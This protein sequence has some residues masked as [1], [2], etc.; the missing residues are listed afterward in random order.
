MKLFKKLTAGA[1]F[2]LASL[3]LIAQAERDELVTPLHDS[4]NYHQIFNVNTEANTNDA[5]LGD[6][7]CAD[8]F[9]NCSLKAALDEVYLIR[10]G[11]SEVRGRDIL[12]RIMVDTIRWDETVAPS[13]IATDYETGLNSGWL[14]ELTSSVNLTIRGYEEFST[15]GKST[16]ILP[17][18]IQVLQLKDSHLW[19]D[20]FDIQV[21][22]SSDRTNTDENLFLAEFSNATV[23]LTEV[24]A[25]RQ[26]GN[27]FFRLLKLSGKI[28]YGED[29]PLESITSYLDVSNSRFSGFGFPLNP[30]TEEPMLPEIDLPFPSGGV[31]LLERTQASFLDTYFEKST[32]AL[33]GAINLSGRAGNDRLTINNSE[34]VNNQAKNGGAVKANCDCP[35]SINNSSFTLN[36]AI[37]VPGGSVRSFSG[38]GAVHFAFY[39]AGTFGLPT[40]TVTNSSFTQNE[41]DQGGA[42]FTDGTQAQNLTRNLFSQNLA[43]RSGGAAYL[44]NSDGN[45]S[46]YNN[47]FS[48]NESLEVSALHISGNRTSDT[49][50][51]KVDI[52]I[53]QSNFIANRSTR[54]DSAVSL[55][56]FDSATIAKSRFDDNHATQES[57]SSVMGFRASALSLNRGNYAFIK[58]SFFR[59]NIGHSG[60]GLSSVRID[61]LSID[62][63]DFLH[64]EAHNSRYH[65]GTGLGR[66]SAIFVYDSHCSFVEI[67]NSE[68]KH[69]IA[70]EDSAIF[71]F[72]YCVSRDLKEIYGGHRVEILNT[73]IADNTA[74]GSLDSLEQE[75]SGIYVRGPVL[76]IDKSFIHSNGAGET[77]TATQN[78]AISYNGPQLIINQSTISHN[79]G[80]TVGGVYAE[81]ASHSGSSRLDYDANSSITN[82]TISSNSG[83]GLMFLVDNT[84]T[85][86]NLDYSTVT[87][88][89]NLSA[90]NG[91]GI[92]VHS[93]NKANIFSEGMLIYGNDCRG[94]QCDCEST[95]SDRFYSTGNNLISNNDS[96][97]HFDSL[98]GLR[99]TDKRI[100][101]AVYAIEDVIN[102]DLELNGASLTPNH[103]LVEGSPAFNTERVVTRR[104]VCEGL[105]VDQR[106]YS[107]DRYCER[108]AIE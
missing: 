93:T 73:E 69:N 98:R 83:K 62:N 66:G 24:N 82:S 102:T 12:I 38:G 101:P 74:G 81:I 31:F 7:I 99:A 70:D 32:S 30:T 11:I 17:E 96:D 76:K 87:L 51:R 57:D 46:V 21:A 35:M 41:A 45:T 47:L 18:R 105:S 5:D 34:F 54:T 42:I 75:A 15:T 55:V 61:K 8:I 40:L 95:G 103:A 48:E 100:D 60:A 104:D 14:F 84:E 64:N 52:Q 88:N 26:A 10:K 23:K 71:V 1:F 9:G 92:V 108:G 77:A 36:K 65:D 43:H 79:V 58:D 39:E 90:G 107:R 56:F 13:S 85:Q 25:Q 19:L 44:T 78:G 89:R 53:M 28:I 91:G 50:Q 72:N 22:S 2:V 27:G 68:I 63:T 4:T 37:D 86:L 16:W 33:G 49:A 29:I 3:P 80:S 20:N 106:G 6:G 94:E 67:K 59:R 97:C